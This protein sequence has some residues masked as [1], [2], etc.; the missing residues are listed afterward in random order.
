MDT[1][2]RKRIEILTDAPLV[3]R[4]AAACEVAGISGHTV[5]PALSGRGRS[6]KWS[7]DRLSGAQSKV[8]VLAI[9]SPERADALLEALAPVLDSHRL[10]VSVGDV[11]VIRGE[12]FG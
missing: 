7:E 6:G 3:P 8:I 10:L 2:I 9:A 1:V 12:R 5:I 11:A 4:I